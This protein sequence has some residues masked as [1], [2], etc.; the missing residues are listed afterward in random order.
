M[1]DDFAIDI[2]GVEMPQE[3]PSL[4]LKRH[5]GWSSGRKDRGVADMT[6]VQDS[7]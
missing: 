2:S 5:V 1:T 7:R 4:R 6:P 3:A